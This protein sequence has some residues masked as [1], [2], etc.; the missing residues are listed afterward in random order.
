MH[1]VGADKVDAGGV[2][3]STKVVIN[4]HIAKFDL[5]LDVFLKLLDSLAFLL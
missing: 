2:N 1:G 3:S 4:G 5:F